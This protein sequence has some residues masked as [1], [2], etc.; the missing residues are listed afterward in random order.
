MK[1]II[2]LTL[3]LSCLLSLAACT[4]GTETPQQTA[5]GEETAQETNIN[6]IDFSGVENLDDFAD[7][8]DNSSY[9]PQITEHEDG[10]I[11][12]E[13]TNPNPTK[14]DKTGNNDRVAI[15]T[16]DKI[17]KPTPNDKE[18]PTKNE[19]IED[20]ETNDDEITS[21]DDTKEEPTPEPE[22][23]P[24]PEPTP[25]P[26]PEPTPEP[27]PEPEPEPTPEPTPEVKPSNKTHTYTSGQTHKTL[28]YTKRYLYSMLN[29]TQKEQY[30]TIDKAVKNLEDSAKFNVKMSEGRNYYIYYIYMFDNPEL[31]YLCNG[32]CISNNTD[33]TSKLE[34]YYSDGVNYNAYGHN[35]RYPTAELRQS[36]LNKKA[37]FDKKVNAIVSTIPSNAPDI[38]KERLIY[39]YIL[40]HSY[41]NLGAQWNG[42]CEDNWN[43]YGILVNGYGVCESYSEAFQTLC[44]AVGINCTGI[45]GSAGGGHKWNAIQLDGEW[46]VCDIT[47]DDPLGNSPDSAYHYYFNRTTA[48]MEENGHTTDNSDFPGP[49]C[50]ATKYDWTK[51]YGESRW[52]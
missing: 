44:L 21:N 40:L 14:D 3:A 43:A 4:K 23:E 27:T 32:V 37:I 17:V 50:T 19:V 46:Y 26:E 51:Y 5:K 11:T 33:G 2:S 35:P 9:K 18:E 25:E 49:V 12:V 41:Y 7:R 52:E 20:K 38:E 24:T 47:F 13:L 48:W 15:P 42:M 6:N 36:I 16:I 10:V 29:A 45:V 22:P 34:F 28:D 39:D 31:F 1:K 30:R 8:L